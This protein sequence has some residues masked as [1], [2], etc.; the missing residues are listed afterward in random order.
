[1]LHILM[2]SWVLFDLGAQVE[3]T[4]G[5]SRYLVFYFVVQ[6]DRISGELFVVRSAFDRRILGRNFRIDRRHDRHGLAGPLVLRS[7]VRRMYIRWADLLLLLG[8]LP[9][10]TIDNAAHIGG[11]AG[12][13]GVGYLAR[14]PG[15]S[16]SAEGF[17][18]AASVVALA[19]TAAAFAE[20]FQFLIAHSR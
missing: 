10:F 7:A 17:W 6:H 19:I 18:R 16:R 9:F 13:F 20:M 5:T 4:Y 2:N 8:L 15:I 11:L 1:M 14:T 12:G 3:E